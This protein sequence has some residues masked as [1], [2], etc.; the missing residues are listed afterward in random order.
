MKR[1]DVGYAAVMK[2]LKTASLLA[3]ALS[4]AFVS[5]PGW[6]QRPDRLALS[7]VPAAALSRD[8]WRTVAN[9]VHTAESHDARASLAEL[10]ADAKERGLDALVLTDHNSTAACVPAALESQDADVTLIPGEEWSSK[11]WGHAG[12]LGYDGPAVLERDGVEGALEAADRA[13]ALAIANHP[14]HWG[15]SWQPGFQDA[16]VGGVEVWNGFWG[17]PLAQN[18][19]ALGLWDAALRSGRRLVAMGGADYH[20]YFYARIDQAVNRV[21]VTAPGRDGIMDGLRQGRVQIAAS[22][23]APWLDLTVDGHGMG[24]ALL[25][26]GAHRLRIAVEGGKGLELRVVTRDGVMARQRVDADRAQFEAVLVGTSGAPDFV[27]AELRESGRSF[28]TLQVL[29]NPVYLV[30]P[31]QLAR[32]P[33][34]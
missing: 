8:G 25:A 21:Q 24:E 13:G 19:S 15:L 27:R 11:R 4:A 26:A 14:T 12:I 2:R 23:A 30:T 17:N 10:V 9:H 18:E 33:S 34:P 1:P 7:E 28:D 16:R 6:A 32:K 31:A 29:T 5:H 3:L 20:G 22:P